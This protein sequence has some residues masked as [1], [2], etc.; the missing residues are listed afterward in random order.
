ML[1]KMSRLITRV[2]FNLPLYY[3]AVVLIKNAGFATDGPN[4]HLEI[5]ISTCTLK[6]NKTK[7]CSV[8]YLQ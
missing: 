8:D 2:F 5:R 4:L 7:L 6:L 1:S 3:I